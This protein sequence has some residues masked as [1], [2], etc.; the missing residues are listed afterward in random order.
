AFVAG[1]MGAPIVP[2]F[3]VG[4]IKMLDKWGILPRK[5]IRLS[6]FHTSIFISNLASL[7]MN[8]VYHHLYEFGTTSMFITLG[9]PR[10]V[11]GKG[12]ETRRVITF[13]ASIDD[14]VS[15]GAAWSRG[16]FELKKMLENPQLLIHGSSG[17]QFTEEKDPAA[18]A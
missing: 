10:R 7:K 17:I 1:L 9:M 13:G 12:D 14:R 8:H 11:S 4:S 2:G 6:P 15:T 5:I 3:L 16:F 18:I